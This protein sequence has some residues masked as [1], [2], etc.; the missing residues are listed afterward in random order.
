MSGHSKI[1]GV[2]ELD[3]FS[4]KEKNLKTTNC[5]CGKSVSNCPFWNC[6]EENVDCPEGIAVY[7]K[8]LDFLLNRE[9]Y[10]FNNKKKNIV[11]IRK[12]LKLNERIYENI[13]KC[14]GKKIVFDSSKE[15]NRAELLLL[16]NKL[17]IILLHLIR[18][19]RGVMWSYKRKYG[20]TFSPM[21][22]WLGLNLKCEMVKRRNRVETIFLKYEDL[23]RNPKKELEEIL[24]RVG[25]NFESQ[26]LN[27]RD[28][29][30]HQIGGNRVRFRDDRNLREDL[31][32]R[33]NLSLV[34]KLTFDLFAGWLNK[35]YGYVF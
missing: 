14:S 20:G 33:K 8:K 22:R 24:K 35:I 25:L 16:S 26:M 1:I 28:V 5:T 29:E 2:G 6:V 18:D 31:S 23:V 17:D 34:D 10:V 32:W 21:W 3:C 19:G 9:K 4:T 13:L 27:F 30:Q 15:V 7:R 11:N 12:Y